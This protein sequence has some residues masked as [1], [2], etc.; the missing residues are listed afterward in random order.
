MKYYLIAGEASGDLH[1]SNL[2]KALKQK[3]TGAAFRGWGGDRMKQEG[4]HLVKHYKDTAFMGFTEVIKHL[5][6][7]LRNIGICKKDILLYRPDAIVLVDYPGFNLRIARF[8]KKNHFRVFYFISPQVWAW[9]KSRVHK[10]IQN[11]DRVFTILPFEKDFYASYN[12]EVD[13]VGHPLLDEIA[14]IRDE[15]PQKLPGL[16]DGD[17]RPVV[18]LLPGSRKQEIKTMLRIMVKIIPQFPD[19]QFVIAG[20]KNVPEHIYTDITGNA[21]VKIVY[22]KTYELLSLSYAA[23]VTS[24]TATLETALLN[25]PQVICYKGSFISYQ[26]AKRLVRIKYIG[27]VN[28]IMDKPLVTELI[29]NRL[30]TDNLTDELRRIISDNEKRRKILEDYKLLREK[31]GGSG[32]SARTAEIIFGSLK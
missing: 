14:L 6:E 9:K 17:K 19:Y 8:A 5:G 2:M 29:Q 24:G 30:N 11:T 10:I 22:D 15:A 20:L 26:I 3:D 28:I 4:L 23:L 21:S 31:L 1:A 16:D 12:Y 32:A 7:I 27:L 18:A 13:F 25:V